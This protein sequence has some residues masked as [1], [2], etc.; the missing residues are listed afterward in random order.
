MV[1]YSSRLVWSQNSAPRLLQTCFCPIQTPDTCGNPFSCRGVTIMSLSVGTSCAPRPLSPLAHLIL[2]AALRG[3]PCQSRFS[4]GKTEAQRSQVIYPKKNS[5]QVARFFFS[6]FSGNTT[7]VARNRNL[8]GFA[9]FPRT[10][11]W[12]LSS[13]TAGG[14]RGAQQRCLLAAEAS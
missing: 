3:G 10:V 5:W 13:A 12:L 8:C 1:L 14:P 11:P 6:F 2:M 7:L 4:D 9:P